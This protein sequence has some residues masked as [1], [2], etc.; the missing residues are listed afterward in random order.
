M[1]AIALWVGLPLLPLYIVSVALLGGLLSLVL[2]GLRA[3]VRVPALARCLPSRMTSL[4]IIANRRHVPYA[5]AISGAG[6]LVTGRLP[7][8]MAFA[9]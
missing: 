8:F 6:L 7:I 5:V 1:A 4:P 9:F 2:L 3:L